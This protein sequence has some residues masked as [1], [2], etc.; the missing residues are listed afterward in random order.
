MPRLKLKTHGS[1]EPMPSLDVPLPRYVVVKDRAGKIQ[2]YFQ[3][4]KRLRP[5]GWP[6]AQRLPTDPLKRTGKADA[7]E[8]AAV[9]ADGI[10]LYEQLEAER[11]GKKQFIRQYSLPWLI[12][13][14]DTYLKTTPRERPISK[15][16]WRNYA[17]CAK[18]VKA[19]AKASGDPHV[20]TITRPGCIAFIGTMNATPTKRRLVAGY[21]RLLMGHAM[22]LGVRQDNPATRLK[23]GTPKA[24]VHI[25]RDDELLMMV[26]AGDKEGLED[27]SNAMLIAHDEGPRPCDVLA[28]QRPR[29]YGKDGAFRYFQQKTEEWVVSPAGQRVRA[30]LAGHP[31]ERL[32][33]VINKTTGKRY[34]QR[35]FQRDFDWLRQVTGLIHLQFRHLRH[36]FVVKAKRAG[37]DAFEIASKTGHDPKS[38]EDM[39]SKHYLPHDSEVATNAT[40]QIEAYR[41]KNKERKSDA[42]V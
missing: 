8:L 37:L 10:R 41:E 35:V 42:N 17:Y 40:A 3:I 5:D 4:P 15:N 27:V 12:Q 1:K 18:Q 7:D 24:K 23:L 33:L 16:T 25:W 30:R 14:Y 6:G 34:N 22:D 29:D 11:G 20:A 39:L 36:T 32:M 13:D 19:W 21:L 31:A 38:V 9:T 2:F 26:A 28:F